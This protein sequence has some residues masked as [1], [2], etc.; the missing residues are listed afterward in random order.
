MNSSLSPGRRFS[1]LAAVAA[2]MMA[3]ATGCGSEEGTTD[4]TQ[5]M[6][7]PPGSTSPS[8]SSQSATPIDVTTF[9]APPG[10]AGWPVLD[11]KTCAEL[12]TITE[13][14]LLVRVP[15]ATPECVSYENDV[16]VVAAQDIQIS[17]GS[18]PSIDLPGFDG[19]LRS[20]REPASRG[21]AYVAHP[22]GSDVQYLVLWDGGTDAPI[23][24]I[25]A[26]LFVE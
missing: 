3:L 23:E 1:V 16:L 21:A 17:I 26:G 18:E 20:V 15:I 14:E 22:S 2:S 19:T 7:A 25:L 12:G 8:A 24:E 10:A 6:P 11:V 5:P 13:P 4:E 9:P